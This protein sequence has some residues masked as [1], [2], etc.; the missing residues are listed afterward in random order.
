MTNQTNKF[1]IE[2][3]QAK[4]L[5]VGD[6]LYRKYVAATIF[7]GVPKNYLTSYLILDTYL[8]QGTMVF[9]VWHFQTNNIRVDLGW[10]ANFE[11][12]SVGWQRITAE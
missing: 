4:D 12:S 3:L 5:K 8:N 7:E 9:K 10:S 6:F 11:I 1:T 2:Y